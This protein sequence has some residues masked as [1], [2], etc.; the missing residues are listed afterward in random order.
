MISKINL[1]GY[2]LAEAFKNGKRVYKFFSP[3][4]I[5]PGSS[6]ILSSILGG[7]TQGWNPPSTDRFGITKFVLYGIDT[8]VGTC[9]AQ[10]L[11]G[12]FGTDYNDLD[13]TLLTE[14]TAIAFPC[15]KVAH[16]LTV[17]TVP[18]QPCNAVPAPA[19]GIGYISSDVL[20]THIEIC[21]RVGAGFVPIGE[22][23]Y[24]SLAA[25]VGQ[26]PDPTDANEYVYAIEQ[27]PAMFK[28]SEVS[29]QFRWK[30]EFGV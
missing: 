30:L 2:F 9:S 12:D 22:T 5:T 14:I 10:M 6:T 8:T 23:W 21:V 11:A 13:P 7:R 29:F 28:T 25:L 19:S 3:N 16:T 4:K 15:M 27:F 1:R 18:T 24:Y 17:S 26:S 20:T